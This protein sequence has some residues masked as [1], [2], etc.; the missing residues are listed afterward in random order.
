MTK[1]KKYKTKWTNNAVDLGPYIEKLQDEIDTIRDS[2]NADGICEANVNEDQIK[3]FSTYS[4]LQL[5]VDWKSPIRRHCDIIFRALQIL[6][7]S[8]SK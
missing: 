3:G 5:E 6:H 2:V 8:E 4:G 7:Y 1:K